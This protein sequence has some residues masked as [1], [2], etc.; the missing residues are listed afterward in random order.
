MCNLAFG[1]FGRIQARRFLLSFA[2]ILVA[3]VM[4]ARAVDAHTTKLTTGN[5]TLSEGETAV[6]LSLALSL[7][8]HDVAFAVGQPILPDAPVTPPVWDAIEA[9]AIAYVKEAV[10][11]GADGVLCGKSLTLF[12]GASLETVYADV[13]FICPGSSKTFFFDYRLFFEI[14]A[15][16]S[17][18]ITL[19][20][21]EGPGSQVVFNSYSAS[22]G[23]DLQKE[24]PTGFSERLSR[25]VILGAE[26]I[27]IGIDHILFLIALL[28][29]IPRLVPIVK[30]ATAFTLGH[31]VTLGLAWYGVFT[32]PGTIVEPI[33]AAS[34]VYVGVENIIRRRPPNHRL[35]NHRWIVALLF[36]LIHGLGFYGVLSDLN[37]ETESAALVLF[38]FNLGVEIGQVL[39]IA[40]ILPILLLIR[41]RAFYPIALRSLSAAM[42]LI[43]AYWFAERVGLI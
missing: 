4:T 10:T 13:T 32:I 12:H 26:H 8:T 24:D 17:A 18:L 11:L 30:L 20:L 23:F 19:N 6:T 33:I 43:A 42:V 21:G 3:F 35:P 28:I 38:G 34:I 5:L 22:L 2:L 15:E 14:D 40:A 1:A 7:S 41:D 36:G 27:L 9:D 31:S 37:L 16:H 29:G 25:L 39:I